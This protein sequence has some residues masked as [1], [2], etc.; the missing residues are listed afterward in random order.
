MQPPEFWSARGAPTPA[1]RLLTPAAALYAA[2]GRLRRRL[3]SPAKSSI[4]VICVGNVTLGGAGKTP[5]AASLARFLVG[6]GRSPHFVSRGHG[7]RLKGPVKIVAKA[8]TAEDV[9][10]EPLLLAQTAPAWIS[11][12]RAAGIAAAAAAGAEVVIADDGFQNPSFEKTFSILMIDAEAGFG[13]GA[14]FPAGPLR[15]RVSDAARRA[16]AVIFNC[17]HADFEIAPEI[18]ASAHGAPAFRAW[19][20]P[21]H[22]APSRVVAFA[23]IGRPAKFFRL[24]ERSG[25]ELAG[26]K[27]FADHHIYDAG[28]IAD[29]QRAAQRLD[30]AL[31]TTEKDYLRLPP[32]LRSGVTC[33][34]IAM[35][36]DRP[37]TLLELI[38]AALDRFAERDT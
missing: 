15:E 17:P 5:C 16:N 35:E 29:L 25:Y 18:L 1:Q 12:N 27:S 13:N 31:I 2:A 8:Q 7:G 21:L 28:E 10:D 4:P 23:G 20:E 34:P 11:R 14:T 26:A 30:A 22:V 36:F 9:G 19:P 3:V 33:F 38:A 6:L 32:A 37:D 24:L